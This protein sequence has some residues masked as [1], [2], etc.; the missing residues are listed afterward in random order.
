MVTMNPWEI[1]RPDPLGV[2][3]AVSAPVVSTN[4]PQAKVHQVSAE[5]PSDLPEAL[6][7]PVPSGEPHSRV[8]TAGV[9]AGWR[10]R[11]DPS[12]SGRGHASRGREADGLGTSFEALGTRRPNGSGS[13]GAGHP[14]GPSFLGAYHSEG[15]GICHHVDDRER[16]GE[17][18]GK[19]HQS[20]IIISTV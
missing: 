8:P 19:G 11:S 13:R 3:A 7:I 4:L 5:V 10:G 9:S 15:T 14:A 1:A 17:A 2:R 6:N 12:E 18:V 20:S 16:R